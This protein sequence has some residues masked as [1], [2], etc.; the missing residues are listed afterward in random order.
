[1]SLFDPELPSSR[2]Y[3]IEV[4]DGGR[5]L[6]LVGKKH[7]VAY[8]DNDAPGLAKLTETMEVLQRIRDEERKKK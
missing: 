8:A 4:V 6:R 3:R 2:D 1:M 5:R 7:G